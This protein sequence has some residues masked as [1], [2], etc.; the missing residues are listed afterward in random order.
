[1]SCFHPKQY[2]IILINIP[3]KKAIE[4]TYK[5]EKQIILIDL[6]T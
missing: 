4:T 5:W 2:K 3:V 6:K 1:M